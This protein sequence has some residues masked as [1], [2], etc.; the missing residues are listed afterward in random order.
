MV[1]RLWT[2][3]NLWSTSPPPWGTVRGCFGAA[4]AGA[5]AA[6]C[7]RLWTDNRGVKNKTENKMKC[8]PSATKVIQSEGLC[9]GRDGCGGQA[10]QQWCCK[11]K[12]LNLLTLDFGSDWPHKQVPV[13]QRTPLNST[14][15]SLDLHR[16]QNHQPIR[17]N[18]SQ[19][20]GCDKGGPQTTDRSKNQVDQVSQTRP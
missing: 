3:Q 15:S 12:S 8:F 16:L 1:Y 17:A 9:V 14:V 13:A 4:A 20:E 6:A 18:K 19:S 11:K 7:G 10:G 5:A 2:I